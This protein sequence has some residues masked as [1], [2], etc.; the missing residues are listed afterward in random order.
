VDPFL[1]RIVT[2]AEAQPDIRAVVMTGSRGRGD[3]SVDAASDYDLEVFTSDPSR[4]EKDEWMAELGDVW[5]YLPTTSDEHEGYLMRL[6]VFA[7]AVKVD[8]GFAPLDLLAST[9]AAGTLTALYDRG[10]QVLVDK[11]GLAARLPEPA[12]RVHSGHLP[13]ADVFGAAVE[14]F[15]FEASHIPKLL[16]RDELWV[17]KMRDWTM[18]LLLLQMVEWHALA[19]DPSRDVWHI[20]TRMQEWA[21]PGVWQRLPETF[22]GFDHEESLRALVALMRLYRDLAVEV[23]QRL[24]YDYPS[25]ADEAVSSYVE[26]HVG[27]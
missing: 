16:S 12:R 27:A 19:S 4:Y 24:G 2:W 20:G 22:G 5:V 13:T 10:Y 23:A 26:R 25:H 6:V 7:D 15:W 11:D 17:V 9:V 14:E 18:K 21:A 1:D 8:F 3:G